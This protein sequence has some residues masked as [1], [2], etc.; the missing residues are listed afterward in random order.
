[1]KRRAF[2]GLLAALILACLTACGG[3]GGSNGSSASSAPAAPSPESPADMAYPSGGEMDFGAAEYEFQESV[4][5][6][7]GS[8]ALRD[9]KM[10][11]TADLELET[12]AFEESTEGLRRLTEEL[13]G[14]FETTSI[15][16]S[17]G[18]R[19]ANYTIRVPAKHYD[20]FLQRAGELCHLT[21]QV[22][23]QENITEAYYDTEGRL[24]TQQIKLERLQEL[25]AKAEN[26]EDIITIESAISETE[27][28]IEALSGE[29]RHYDAL[30]DYATITLTI[31]E[32]YK[33]SDTEVT[34]DSFGSRLAASFTSGLRSF[35]SG[36]ED[37]AVWLAYSWLWLVILAVIL[38]VCFRI[39]RSRKKKAEANWNARRGQGTGTGRKNPLGQFPPFKDKKS[40]DKEDN[41]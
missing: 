11:L 25:L 19:W 27:Y 31:S 3:G 12:T 22:T 9:A 41:P 23:G 14:Y 37:F 8:G 16:G 30:V 1:M 24:K 29:L 35:G 15:R 17:G 26:M 20:A 34:P 2:L 10:I 18:S 39:A 40:D 38:L 5:A 33:L 21:W 13:E 32:V 6:D 28:Q 36:M 4:S 7:S